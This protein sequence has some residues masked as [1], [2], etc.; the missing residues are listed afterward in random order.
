MRIVKVR[1]RS[2]SGAATTASLVVGFEEAV[3]LCELLTHGAAAAG[4]PLEVYPPQ[5]V[6]EEVEERRRSRQKSQ[7][8]QPPDQQPSPP[9]SPSGQ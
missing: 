9:R 2:T 5:D 3:L 6:R 7:P 4:E 8:G 1:M